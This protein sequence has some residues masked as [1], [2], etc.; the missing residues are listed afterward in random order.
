MIVSKGNFNHASIKLSQVSVTTSNWVKIWSSNFFHFAVFASVTNEDVD[1]RY[2]ACL[3]GLLDNV[4]HGVIES[5]FASKNILYMFLQSY[6]IVRIFWAV[7]RKKKKKT[8]R[9]ARAKRDSILSANLVLRVLPL[10]KT[11]RTRVTFDKWLWHFALS[12]SGIRLSLLS[13]CEF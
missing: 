6:K 11:L 3:F 9:L 7:L 8:V 2:K 5:R 13:G 4:T 12:L 1:A 10:E